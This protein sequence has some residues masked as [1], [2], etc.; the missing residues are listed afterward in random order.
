MKIK[1]I[2]ELE[3]WLSPPKL[4]TGLII[5]GGIF[6]G[7]S[8]FSLYVSN[9]V[10]Y[11]SDRPETC[12]N[13]HIMNPQYATWS[14]SSHREKANCND[15][16]VPH[17]N[18]VSKYAFKAMDGA[19]HATMFTLRAEPQVIQIKEAGKKAVQENCKRCHWK[20]NEEV[21]T[22]VSATEIHEGEG[23]FCWECHRETPHG[24]I[25]S[26]A[27]TPYALVP[28]L[29]SPVPD[30]IKEFVNNNK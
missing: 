3:K 18:P 22:L 21:N 25:N 13:C 2:D 27:S 24:R 11:L 8:I 9:A 17:S 26:L 29:E 6:V 19:R 1:I 23:R 20:L 15:C 28:R 4:R 12:I 10:S 7:L 5:L 14:H 30:W 16:H